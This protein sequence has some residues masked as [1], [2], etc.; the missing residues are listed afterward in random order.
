M[1]VQKAGT[2]LGL[3]PAGTEEGQA[4]ELGWE[5]PAYSWVAIYFAG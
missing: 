5:L 2:S 1:G 4:D 3:E